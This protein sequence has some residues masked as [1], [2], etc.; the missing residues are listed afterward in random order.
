MLPLR[1]FLMVDTDLMRSAATIAFAKIYALIGTIQ[2][3]MSKPHR[4]A[5]CG[6]PSNYSHR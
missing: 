4:I 3:I 5:V 6:C 1:E 2:A